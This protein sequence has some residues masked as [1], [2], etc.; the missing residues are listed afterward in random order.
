MPDPGRAHPC[1]GILFPVLFERK[2]RSYPAR[3]PFSRLQLPDRP[4]VISRRLLEQPGFDWTTNA[5]NRLQEPAGESSEEINGICEELRTLGCQAALMTGSG[6]CCFGICDN[7]SQARHIAD[8]VGQ[9][10]S[11]FVFTCRNL[12]KFPVRE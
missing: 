2:N 7:A 6:S 3:S 8:Q 11:R 5:F 10:P 1:A 4:H 12:A 9:D